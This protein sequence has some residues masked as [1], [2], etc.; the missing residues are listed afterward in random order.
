MSGQRLRNWMVT[1]YAEEFSENVKNERIQYAVWQREQCPTTG[2]LHWQGY[3]EF[4]EGVSMSVVKKLLK[5]NTVHLEARKGTQ[6]Q[7]IA[8]CTK[9]ES[10]VSDFEEWGVKK[11]DGS[12]TGFDIAVEMARMNMKDEDI[13]SECPGEWVRY[14]KGLKSVKPMVRRNWKPEVTWIW[15]A[16][17]AGKSRMAF[18]LLGEDA[19]V[20]N[21]SSKWWDLYD[22]DENV[23]IDDYKGGMDFSELLRVLDR[24]PMVV[25]FKGGSCSFVAKK[26]VVTSINK[27]EFYVPKGEPKEQLLRRIDTITQI[28]G[29]GGNTDAHML[30]K[31]FSV[32]GEFEGC[33]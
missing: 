14:N 13:K 9:E 22:G 28:H 27:P 6:E 29:V 16:S 23:I 10:R 2:K 11:K 30:D 20:K 5:D 3:L 19:F 15:G 4:K 18:E 31:L 21:P 25:E 7:A 32:D 17:G 8:Y 26:I 1:S 33:D 12:R 24:Y